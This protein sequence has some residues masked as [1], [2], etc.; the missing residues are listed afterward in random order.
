MKNGAAFFSSRSKYSVIL[1]A[2]ATTACAASNP[3]QR[4]E[5]FQR[6]SAEEIVNSRI[7]YDNCLTAAARNADDGKS[8]AST[9]AL[10]IKSKCFPQ[11]ERHVRAVAAAT[12]RGAKGDLGVSC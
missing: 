10:A 9:I 12:V 7:A 6:A 4:I 8:D 1:V 5:T 11:A 3:P 2:F